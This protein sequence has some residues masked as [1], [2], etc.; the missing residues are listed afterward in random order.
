MKQVVCPECGSQ[1]LRHYTDAYLVWTPVLED[2]GTL[3]KLDSETEEYDGFFEC[4][5][6]GHRPSEEEL[7]AWAARPVSDRV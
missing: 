1:R 7:L 6:C 4:R 2:D 3:G 5:D